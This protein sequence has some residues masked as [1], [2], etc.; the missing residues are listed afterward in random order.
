MFLSFFGFSNVYNFIRLI[1]VL[2]ETFW[3]PIETT[4]SEFQFYKMEKELLQA[5]KD[6]NIDKVN[7]IL[8]TDETNINCKDI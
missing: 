5:S 2:K 1:S 7:Q 3:D 8:K 6:G 4:F